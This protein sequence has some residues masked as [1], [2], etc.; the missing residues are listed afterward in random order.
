MTI[1]ESLAELDAALDLCHPF[2]LR[3]LADLF[4]RRAKVLTAIAAIPAPVVTPALVA[5]LEHS[6]QSGEAARRRLLVAQHTLSQELASLNEKHSY[7][8]AIQAQAP[9]TTTGLDCKG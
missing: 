4:T 9:L 5:A 6:I 7:A 1:L 2:D 3:Q 8:G